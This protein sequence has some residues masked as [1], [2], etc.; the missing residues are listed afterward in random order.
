MPHFYNANIIASLEKLKSA[1]QDVM[2]YWDDVIDPKTG[3]VKSL[4]DTVAI[5]NYPF[6]KSFDEYSISIHNWINDTINE[7]THTNRGKCPLCTEELQQLSTILRDTR[8]VI[9]RYSVHSIDVLYAKLKDLERA[10]RVKDFYQWLKDELPASNAQDEEWDA[11]Y[12]KKWT[13]MF[14]DECITL[15]NE[16]T[17]YNFITDMFD[18]YINNCL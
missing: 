10:E 4:N 17:I 16:A 3:E 6:D 18:F 1:Y 8:D 5:K 12:N 9:D 2:A 15:E 7:I 13:I 14:G 11:Y